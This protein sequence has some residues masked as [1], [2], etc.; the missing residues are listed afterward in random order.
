MTS[1]HTTVMN[2]S[3]IETKTLPVFEHVDVHD[4]MVALPAGTYVV[5][6]PCYTMGHDLWRGF[7]EASDPDCF[8]D[9]TSNMAQ[10]ASAT[11]DGFQIVSISTA[12]G[13]GRYEDGAG[14]TYGVDSGSLGLVPIGFVEKYGI[15]PPKTASTVTTFDTEVCCTFDA[16]DEGA[17]VLGPLRILTDPAPEPFVCWVCLCESEYSDGCSVNGCEED[18]F[19]DDDDDE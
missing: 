14:N 2:E 10:V 5:G 7:L 6:D 19:E 13:D 9:R 12:Y 17:V 16:A 8:V 4:D 1:A 15:L 3:Q 18:E 11:V